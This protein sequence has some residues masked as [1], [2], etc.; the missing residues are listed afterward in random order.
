LRISHFDK[1]GLCQK[2][3]QKDFDVI[4]ECS[5]FHIFSKVG[6]SIVILITSLNILM[7]F[8]PMVFNTQGLAG[9]QEVFKGKN[10]LRGG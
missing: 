10:R 3:H 8:V 5:I 4:I 2:L 7:A 9:P 6:T 1:K